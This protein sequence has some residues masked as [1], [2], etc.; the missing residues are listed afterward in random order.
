MKKQK[1]DTSVYVPQK[2]KIKNGL[3]ISER[4]IWTEKQKE[5]INLILNKQT[6]IVFCEGVSGTAK[7]LLS[8][9]CG[10]E[11]L[12]K[13]LIGQLYYTRTPVESSNYGLGYIKGDASEKFDPYC[14]PIYDKLEELLDK[15]SIDLLKKEERVITMPLGF[16]RGASLNSTF[17]IAEEAQNYSLKDFLLLMTRLGKFSKLIFIGDTKQSDIRNSG[18]RTVINLFDN[19]ESKEKGI[20]TFKFYKIDIMRNEILS[21]IIEKF[22]TLEK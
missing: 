20:N 6:K 13:K 16:M 12:Q 2:S 21:F 22:E 15:P 14:M 8:V 19:P 4:F 11:L 7:T 10:L 18:F 9:Y 5:F 1:E 3:N 17:I